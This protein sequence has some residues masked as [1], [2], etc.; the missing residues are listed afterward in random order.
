MTIHVPSHLAA[1][2]LDR[3]VDLSDIVS[4]ASF[5]A[6]QAV[7]IELILSADPNA[8][9]AA[10]VLGIPVRAPVCEE[11]HLKPCDRCSRPDLSIQCQNIDISQEPTRSLSEKANC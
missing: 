8:T 1:V 5:T 3:F 11:V 9:R 10:I 7:S 6:T 2:R 4:I